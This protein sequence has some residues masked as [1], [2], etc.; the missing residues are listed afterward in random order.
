MSPIALGIK[1][2]VT[3][4]LNI[5][6]LDGKIYAYA[7]L[8]EVDMCTKSWK[9]FGKRRRISYPCGFNWDRKVSENLVSFTGDERTYKILSRSHAMTLQ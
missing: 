5:K 8:R 3:T 1:M 9:I 2:K 4:D 6:I 7:D